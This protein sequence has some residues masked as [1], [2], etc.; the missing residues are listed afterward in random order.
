MEQHV[1]GLTASAAAGQLDW[2]LV[3]AFLAALWERRYKPLSGSAQQEFMQRSV[4]FGGG[5]AGLGGAGVG[6]AGRA[7]DDQDRVDDDWV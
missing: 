3:N 2:E 4:S 7:G 5:L 6:G 1:K